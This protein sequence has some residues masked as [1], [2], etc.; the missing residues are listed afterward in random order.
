MKVRWSWVALIP[1]AVTVWVP[2]GGCNGT[3]DC[4]A[5]CRRP[6]QCCMTQSGCNPDDHDIPTCV[7]TCEDLSKDAGFKAAMEDQAGCYES[8]TCVEIA[9]GECLAMP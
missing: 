5:Y 3:G 4:D 1:A 8:S 6:A 7:A 9:Q 2:L